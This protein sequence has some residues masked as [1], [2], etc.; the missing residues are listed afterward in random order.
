MCESGMY[1]TWTITSTQ[2]PPSTPC[3][4]DRCKLRSNPFNVMIYEPCLILKP[5]CVSIAKTARVDSFVKIEGGLGVTIGE[6]VHIAS[7]CHLN[8]G[9]GRLVIEDHATCSSGVC[10]GSASP[11]WS[12][13]YISAAD[14][15]EHHHV[16]REITR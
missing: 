12:Y 10:V 9:G 8:V 2:S 1:L 15:P 4:S 5:E 16:R 3:L 7:F 14:P 11:D 13:L 6:Y